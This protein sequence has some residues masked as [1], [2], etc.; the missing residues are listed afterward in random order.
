MAEAHSKPHAVELE[1]MVCFNLHAAYRAVTAAYR[2][3]LEPL[4]VSKAQ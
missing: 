2:P 1:D 3:Q 4:G